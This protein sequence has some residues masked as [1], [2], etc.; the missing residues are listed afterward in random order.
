MS[1]LTEEDVRRIVRDELKAQNVM[2]FNIV[3]S[4]PAYAIGSIPEEPK[5]VE[6]DRDFVVKAP[7]SVIG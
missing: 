2:T 4:D 7:P 6:I 5:W 3:P 1:K